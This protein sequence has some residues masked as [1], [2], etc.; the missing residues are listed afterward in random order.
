M[1]K[2]ASCD[3]TSSRRWNLEVHIKR[4]HNGA[5]G[6]VNLDFNYNTHSPSQID[7]GDKV[8]KNQNPHKVH[9][10]GKSFGN[11]SLKNSF[12]FIDEAYELVQKFTTVKEFINR[13]SRLNQPLLSLSLPVGATSFPSYIQSDYPTA[14]FPSNDTSIMENIVAFRG[15]VCMNCVTKY[16][17]PVFWFQ[18][19]G[20][21]VETRH[22]CQNKADFNS[23]LH[24]IID[25]YSGL[26]KELRDAVNYWS[27]YKPI[28]VSEPIPKLQNDS[29]LSISDYTSDSWLSRVIDNG[30]T[31]LNDKELI[32]F[33]CCCGNQ[34][35]NCFNVYS[36]QQRN[37]GVFLML[38]RK[39]N[40]M[41]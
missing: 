3:Q 5:A 36:K 19:T 4:K 18:E 29:C 35:Y 15:Y 16:I 27:H 31:S 13:N 26:M 11:S 23:D 21:L 12:D 32:E 9:L 40:C 10:Y 28:L 6:P 30:E 2:C 17:I 20:K 37:L 8:H 33:L 34:T 41:I 14:S 39:S 25:L 38:M 7:L 1:W 24:N 22:Q